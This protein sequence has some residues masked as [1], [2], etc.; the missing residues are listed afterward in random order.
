MGNKKNNT[1]RLTV[2]GIM[3]ALGTVLSFVKVFELPYGGSITLFSMVPVLLLGFMF[4]IKWGFFCGAVFGA[5]QG[6]LG[7]TMSAAFAGQQ[8][9][10][11]IAV[12]MIDYIIAFAVL[13]LSGMFKYK[14]KNP[15]LAFPLGC[16]FTIFLRFCAH[17]ISGVIIWGSYAQST[18]E[19]VKN[20]IST[21]ILENFTGTGLAAMYSL[22]YNASYM[23]P[24]MILSVFAA[25]ILI[26]V[27]P[28]KKI[29]SEN[30]NKI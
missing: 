26:N 3:I 25:V 7:A 22:V 4:G 13:G 14:M 21:A 27:K 2:S 12:L 28:I 29:A 23:L 1:Q 5:L 19:G 24:E 30:T 11:V 10:G 18:L 6:L 17:F 16:V 8:F 9:A 15:S 20:S